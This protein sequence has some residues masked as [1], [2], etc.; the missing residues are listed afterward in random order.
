[1]LGIDVARD[2]VAV[3]YRLGLAGQ[4]AAVDPNLTGQENLR[5][6]GRLAQMP[7]RQVRVRSGELLERFDLAEAADRGELWQMIRELVAEGTTVLLTTQ[8][9]EEADR[10]A[11]RIAVIDRGRVIANDTP[12]ALEAHLGSTVIEL[13]MGDKTRAT[14]AQHLLSASLP[15]RPEREPPPSAWPPRTGRTC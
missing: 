2:P 15:T 13:G 7:G 5:L 14:Q 3:R 9:L 4:Y 11:Q 6:I 1:M 10:L 12:A 8:Y